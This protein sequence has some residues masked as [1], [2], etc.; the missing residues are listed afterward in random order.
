MYNLIMQHFYGCVTCVCVCV[1]KKKLKIF[2]VIFSCIC[3]LC[4]LFLVTM[5]RS[6]EIVC[7]FNVLVV[8]VTCRGY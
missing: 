1:F 3:F 7:V 8:V 5:E 4:V 6:K 2:D